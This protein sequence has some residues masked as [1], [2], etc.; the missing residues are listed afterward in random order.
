MN[1]YNKIFLGKQIP[2]K[3]ANI[4]QV[5]V[6]A[7]RPRI[8]IAPLKIGLAVQMYHHY[9]S[10]FLLQISSKKRYNSSYSKQTLMRSFKTWKQYD[11]RLGS[12]GD[13]ANS[14]YIWVQY[15]HVRFLTYITSKQ[16]Q[17]SSISRIENDTLDISKIYANLSSCS[18]FSVDSCLR[19]IINGIL[20]KEHVNAHE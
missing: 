11:G 1:K 8:V 5:I 14:H 3:V 2:Q 9:R 15:C 19:N 13:N 12:S 16:H 20:A 6:Q 7:A 18:P 17:D 4:G 10:K